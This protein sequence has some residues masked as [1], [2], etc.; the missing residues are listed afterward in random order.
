MHKDRLGRRTVLAAAAA[1]LALAGSARAEPAA[2]YASV[3]VD[4]GP[5]R[6]R[7][8]GSY[9]EL[10]R[11]TMQA[12]LSAAFADRLG[13]GG[14]R[15]VVRIDAVSMRDY[16]GGESSRFGGSG[17]ASNDYLEGEA[18]VI[19]RRGEVLLRR[20][21]LSALPASSGG[22][23]YLPDNENRRLAAISRHFAAWLRRG[24]G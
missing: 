7:G 17:G 2:R 19:G 11:A 9:A 16:V 18:M 4:V 24:L 8:L 22:A 23:W 10:V 12:E 20:P 3:S 1:V 5:L 21:Q 6:A 14:P 15:L 13:G